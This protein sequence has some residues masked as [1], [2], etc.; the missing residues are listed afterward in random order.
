MTKSQ[1][2]SIIKLI[3]NEIALTGDEATDKSII[4]GE[5]KKAMIDMQTANKLKS[6]I[7]KVEKE[8]IKKEK[9]EESSKDSEDSSTSK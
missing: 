7:K 4:Q 5:K 8:K 6:G 1:L 3:L 2:K 9:E